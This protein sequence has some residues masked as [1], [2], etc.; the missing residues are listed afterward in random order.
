MKFSIL[1][2]LCSA[3]GAA[4]IAVATAAAPA[5]EPVFA[6]SP[7]I[8]DFFN[9]AYRNLKSPRAI[10]V[11]DDGLHWGYSYCPEHRCHVI[12]SARD[13]AMQAC[14][15]VGG[16]RCRIFAVDDD[17]EISYRVMNLA[18]LRQWLPVVPP[19][20]TSPATA[21]PCVGKTPAQCQ[22][23]AADFAEQRSQI[24][25]KWAKT[26]DEQRRYSCGMASSA[27]CMI[28]KQ[29]EAD[30]DAELTALDAEMRKDLTQ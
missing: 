30:R 28:L 11:A 29:S 9:G 22:K 6:I 27:P 12:P 17:V 1:R 10:A 4:L 20:A 13:L 3:A 2:L 15:K 7:K 14:V 23:I 26:I 25:S 21:L 24:E 18:E 19:K 8:V 5:D 16:Q